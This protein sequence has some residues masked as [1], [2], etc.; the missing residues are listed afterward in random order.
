MGTVKIKVK[1]VEPCDSIIPDHEIPI[2]T[3]FI[4]V[5]Q[6]AIAMTGNSQLQIGISDTVESQR[7]HH[8]R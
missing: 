8:V 7:F 3:C 4:L 1:I 5:R 6:L 2:L